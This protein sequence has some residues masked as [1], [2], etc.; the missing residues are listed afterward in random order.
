MY[1]RNE[2]TLMRMNARNMSSIPL[3]SRTRRLNG[4][5]NAK[6]KCDVSQQVWN[7]QGSSKLNSTK[8]R[9]RF[10]SASAAMLTPTYDGVKKFLNGMLNN[11]IINN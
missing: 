5:V 7:E 2:Y 3:P 6:K 8:Q 4:V 10:C 1:T 11:I 9:L